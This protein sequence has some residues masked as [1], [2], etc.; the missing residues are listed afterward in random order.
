MTEDWKDDDVYIKICKVCS[1]AIEV[2]KKNEHM[3]NFCC[4]CGKSLEWLEDDEDDGN[5]T[6]PF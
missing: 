6:T 5:F 4:S 3:W 2:N 1:I